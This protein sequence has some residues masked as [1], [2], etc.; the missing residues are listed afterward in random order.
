MLKSVQHSA[1]TYARE[2]ISDR[3][4][5]WQR[6]RRALAF[7]AISCFLVIG[8]GFPDL[9]LISSVVLALLITAAYSLLLLRQRTQ[10]EVKAQ[11]RQLLASAIA[12]LMCSFWILLLLLMW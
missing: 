3:Q 1:S 6:V 10:H 5:F 12:V 2:C 8:V 7:V 9:T 11:W 4:L